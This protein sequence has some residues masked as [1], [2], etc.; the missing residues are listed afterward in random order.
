MCQ[1]LY[2]RSR[3]AAVKESRQ[4]PSEEKSTRLI[5]M[6]RVLETLETTPID[7]IQVTE[8]SRSIYISRGTFYLYFDSVADVVDQAQNE[9]FHDFY[10]A[11]DPYVFLPFDDRYFDEPYPFLLAGNRFAKNHKLYYQSLFGPNGNAVFKR[12]ARASIRQFTFDRAVEQRYIVIDERYH[13]VAAEYMVT[14][15]LQ[16]LIPTVTQEDDLSDTEKAV[17]IYRLLFAPYR[18]GWRGEE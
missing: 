3:K 16:G 6:E 2:V 14:G 13:N 4:S 11:V 5:I 8:L 18:P 12:D 9:F 7:Q 15:Y 17:F 1:T 10:E